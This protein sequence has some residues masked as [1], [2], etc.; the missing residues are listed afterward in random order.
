MPRSIWN[1]VIS[2]GM[3]SIPVKLFTA[4]Q[5]KD[6]SF[7]QLHTECNSRIK[8]QLY[9]PVCDRVVTRDELVRGY[10]F[11]KEQHVIVSDEDLEKLPLPSSHT[12][13]L[14]AFVE[15]E[16]IDP[17][18]YER[19]YYLAPDEVGTKPFALLM[20]ALKEKQLTGL[21]KVSL[22][23]KEQLCALRPYDGTLMLETLYYPDEIRVEK[24]ESPDIEVS[25]RELDMAFSLID[26]LT[27]PFDPEKYHDE[28]RTALTEIIEA[29]L[30]GQEIVEQVPL[31]ETKVVDLMAALKASVDAAKKR[32]DEEPEKILAART[33]RRRKAG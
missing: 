17:V 8:Q 27:E 20:R 19:S 7:H 29:K 15:G 28:Y 6:I 2:F 1:G 12:I 23:N 5:S 24:G 22:R 33:P 18:F 14:A 11:T 26:L 21:A 10:E 3:V 25:D 32:K 16:V 9:C 13:E 30:Q 4:T 31:P